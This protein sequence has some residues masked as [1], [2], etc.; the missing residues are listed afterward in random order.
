[1]EW[2]CFCLTLDRSVITKR[3][4]LQLLTSVSFGETGHEMW[5][6]VTVLEVRFKSVSRSLIGI[7]V[8]FMS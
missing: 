4:A 8:F 3:L 1:M 6:A 2:Y 7:S 5:K